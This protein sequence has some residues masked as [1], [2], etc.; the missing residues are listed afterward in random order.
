MTPMLSVP[1]ENMGEDGKAWLA[2]VQSRHPMG[3]LGEPREIADAVVF[4]A[5][6][7]ASFMTGSEVVV[8]GGGLLVFVVANVRSMETD[9]LLLAF[10]DTPLSKGS[11]FL[12]PRKESS[13]H[14]DNI[15]L[16]YEEQV[17]FNRYKH[18]LSACSDS[19][20]ASP[21]PISPHILGQTN[22]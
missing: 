12:S 20:Q 3:R 14:S 16:V 8:D 1:A 19:Q 18:P 4:L 9:R 17:A 22:N 7:E 2:S 5:S 13:R 10:Q 21:L 11:C 6:E 15:F